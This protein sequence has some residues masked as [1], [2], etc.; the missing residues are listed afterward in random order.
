MGL[1]YQQVKT[2]IKSFPEETIEWD[3]AL[4]EPGK[5][6]VAVKLAPLSGEEAELIALKLDQLAMSRQHEGI[7][8]MIAEEF[9]SILTAVRMVKDQ[10]KS[11]FAGI[12]G[13]GAQLDIQWLRAEQIGAS[14][15]DAGT[16]VATEGPWQ[17][18][19]TNWLKT[20]TAGTNDYIIDPQTMAEEA[21]LIH[22]GA[23]DPVEV[24]KVEAVEFELAGIASPAQSC[25]WEMRERFGTDRL[26]VVRWEKPVIC[27]PERKHAIECAPYITGDT[28]MQ[29]L[30]LLIARAQDLTL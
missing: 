2:L 3:K 13:V 29:L 25:A 17:N 28:K 19:L 22:L 23:I 30:S 20:L 24:P 18:G 16:A 7:A 5:Q 14:L 15:L 9:D 21:A 6:K 10:T 8:V 4:I 1:V 27:A 26:P 12:L 11:P